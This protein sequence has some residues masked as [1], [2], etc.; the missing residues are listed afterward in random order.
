[1]KSRLSEEKKN[2]SRLEGLK[3]YRL[4]SR[5][6]LSMIEAKDFAPYPKQEVAFSSGLDNHQK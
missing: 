1:M 2:L 4:A 3:R 6:S 5:E